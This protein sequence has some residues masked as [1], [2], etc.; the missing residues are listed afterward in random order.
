MT[1]NRSPVTGQL[2]DLRDNLYGLD[3][4]NGGSL[5]KMTLQSLTGGEGRLQVWSDPQTASIDAPAAEGDRFYA[6]APSSG[7]AGPGVMLDWTS[8]DGPKTD[9]SLALEEV[10]GAR[11][12]G[13]VPS[14]GSVSSTKRSLSAG[15]T[16]TYAVRVPADH[17]IEITHL[18][19]EDE[20]L[21]TRVVDAANRE[22]YSRDSLEEADQLDASGEDD[23]GYYFAEEA[24]LHLVRVTTPNNLTNHELTVAAHKPTDL[25]EL[26]PG[27]TVDRMVT[28]ATKPVRSDYYRF[29]VAPA[30]EVTFSFEPT[31]PTPADEID[32]DLKLHDLSRRVDN[33]TIPAGRIAFNADRGTV[34]VG[35]IDLTP[36]RYLLGHG[37]EEKLTD[38]KISGNLKPAGAVETEPNDR[39]DAADTLAAD[40]PTVGD[41]LPGDGDVWT[42]QNPTATSSKVV[43]IDVVADEAEADAWHCTLTAPDGTQVDGV[44]MRDKGCFLMARPDQAG[45]WR[46][47]IDFRGEDLQRYTV[48]RTLREARMESE[49]NNRAAL[50]N[51]AGFSGQADE[52]VTLG[53]WTPVDTTDRYR[54]QIPS[55]TGANGKARLFVSLSDEGPDPAGGQVEVR[56][57]KGNQIG[58][59]PSNKEESVTTAVSGGEVF[60]V[61]VRGETST[62]GDADGAYALTASLYEPDVVESASPGVSISKDGTRHSSN[63]DVSNCANPTRVTAGVDIAYQFRSGLSVWLTNPSGQTIQLWDQGGG[64]DSNLVGNIPLTLPSANPMAPLI[65]GSANGQWTMEVEVTKFP[66]GGTWKGWSLQLNCN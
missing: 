41:V 9:Y 1:P 53:R 63:V 7:S 40:T 61:L 25:G 43:T 27:D 52:V 19:D 51:P 56:D 59:V 32:H 23:E 11:V 4:F 28:T 49:P 22:R 14:G 8:A 3:G 65:G 17:V 37:I 30:A 66:F 16:A 20:E 5:V 12:L 29:D 24:G 54:I 13:D 38:L 35:P 21:D 10:T 18:N 55:G 57:G 15:T 42:F 62:I 45:K 2:T 58:M 60:D 31:A 39:V 36:G 48:T 47:D 26:Q 46:V 50:R 6:L 34:T 44:Q 33:L 64:F